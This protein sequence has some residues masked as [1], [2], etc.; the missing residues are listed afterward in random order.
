[1]QNL[2]IPGLKWGGSV[3]GM[4]VY[5]NGLVYRQCFVTD[6]Q[7]HRLN[8]YLPKHIA[9]ARP[10]LVSVFSCNANPDLIVTKG[11]QFDGLVN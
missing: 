11:I 1:M 10:R 4:G 9:R 3:A 7:A 8:F 2:T 5:R 6:Q